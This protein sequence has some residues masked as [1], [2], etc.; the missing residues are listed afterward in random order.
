MVSVYGNCFID[1]RDEVAIDWTQIVQEEKFMK[2]RLVW[3]RGEVDPMMFGAVQG[4]AE[5]IVDACARD[6]ASDPDRWTPENPAYSH[7]AVIALYVQE[8]LGG[9]LLR[10]SLEGMPKYAHMRSHYWNELPDGTQVDLSAS[11]FEESDRDQVPDG[12]ERTREYLTGNEATRK[13]F[14]LLHSRL[15]AVIDKIRKGR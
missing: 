3:V 1:N 8:A 5:K 14:E 10:A 12:E 6:T 2:K 13:R 9:K 15:E 4:M 7:C 11:Q